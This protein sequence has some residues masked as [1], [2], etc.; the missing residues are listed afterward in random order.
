MP[1]VFIVAVHTIKC[2]HTRTFGM[3]KHVQRCIFN[4][5][6]SAEHKQVYRVISMTRVLAVELCTVRTVVQVSREIVCKHK[7]RGV[8]FEIRCCKVLPLKSMC[9]SWRH[10]RSTNVSRKNYVGVIDRHGIRITIE[11]E[12]P[13]GNSKPV[14]YEVER[15]TA[16]E[17]KI[18]GRK[19]V[20]ALRGNG[21]IVSSPLKIT[22]L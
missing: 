14:G 19:Q 22:G 5:K 6:T 7:N 8:L 11:L 13:M 21:W 4:T 1:Y 17:K 3:F 18:C 10:A 12:K 20:V 16:R 15:N 9:A 2:V